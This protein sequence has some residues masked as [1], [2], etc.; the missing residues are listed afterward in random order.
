M[1][2][3]KANLLK[4][5]LVCLPPILIRNMMTH[6]RALG[7]GVIWLLQRMLSP[8]CY[9]SIQWLALA[10]SYT[11]SIHIF[12]MILQIGYYHWGISNYYHPLVINWYVI[13]LVLYCKKICPVPVLL[14]HMVSMMSSIYARLVWKQSGKCN[15]GRRHW[16]HRNHLGGN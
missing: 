13:Y 7:S 15:E 2:L 11:Y 9:T 1:R 3:E 6:C 5:T 12:I 16:R 8:W 14:K 4:W 10:E